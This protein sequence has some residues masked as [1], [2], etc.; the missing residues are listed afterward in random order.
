MISFKLKLN[1]KHSV[2]QKATQFSKKCFVRS[3]TAL[4]IFW[5][6]LTSHTNIEINI[7]NHKEEH[8]QSQIGDVGSSRWVSPLVIAHNKILGIKPGQQVGPKLQR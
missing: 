5:I 7:L 8:I 2:R 6:T 4:C 3:K 1:C